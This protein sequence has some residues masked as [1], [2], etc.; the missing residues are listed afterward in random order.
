[1]YILLNIQHV[2]RPRCSAKLAGECQ[3][4]MLLVGL[5]L[6]TNLNIFYLAAISSG[7]QNGIFT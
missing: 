1:M 7:M 2:V 3:D 5:N 4:I 6:Y